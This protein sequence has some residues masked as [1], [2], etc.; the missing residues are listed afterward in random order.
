[1]GGGVDAG[2]R[3][4]ADLDEQRASRQPFHHL[5]FALGARTAFACEFA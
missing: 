2:T 4:A 1:M 5:R 3:V